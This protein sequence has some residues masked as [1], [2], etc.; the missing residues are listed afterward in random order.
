MK[1]ISFQLYRSV[2]APGIGKSLA[3]IGFVQPASGGVLTM[4]E[5]QARWFAELCKDNVFLPSED[6]MKDDIRKDM[7]SQL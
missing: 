6:D 5:I 2:F 4:S 3:F 7:V 1:H